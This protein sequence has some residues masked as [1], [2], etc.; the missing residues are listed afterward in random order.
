[1]A[2]IWP[3]N[4]AHQ[5]ALGPTERDTTHNCAAHSAARAPIWPADQA[6]QNKDSSNEIPFRI[7]PPIARRRFQYLSLIHI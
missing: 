6:H 3:V 7:A 4:Q 5:N 1:M 2:S